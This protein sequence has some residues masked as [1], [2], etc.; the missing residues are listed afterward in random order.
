M[1]LSSPL[2]PCSRA[3]LCATVPRKVP[4]PCHSLGLWTPPRPTRTLSV[5]SGTRGLCAST[6]ATRFH[7]HQQ[8]SLPLTQTPSGHSSNSPRAGAFGLVSAQPRQWG[9]GEGIAL[10]SWKPRPGSRS[11]TTRCPQ[12]RMLAGAPCGCRPSKPA[13]CLGLV[14]QNNLN[15][16]LGPRGRFWELR[17]CQGTPPRGAGEGKRQ[18]EEIE[19]ARPGGQSAGP[20]QRRC[21]Q[22]AGH[23]SLAVPAQR[24]SARWAGT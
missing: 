15:N 5:G 16:L 12:S 19:D 13:S 24:L 9:S 8:P 20:F 3:P 23:D 21:K 11:P 17:G 1:T 10:L 4:I 22:M 18:G 2:C 6:P 14:E 7:R